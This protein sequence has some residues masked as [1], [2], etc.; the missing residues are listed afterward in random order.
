[1]KFKVYSCVTVSDITDNSIASVDVMYYL[2]TSNTEC[3]G[4]TW[5]TTPPPWE[6][7]KYYWQK[8]VTTFTDTSIQPSETQP[9]CI[10]GGKGQDGRGVQS[11]TEE[12]YLSTSKEE[13]IGGEWK[14]LNHNGLKA[15]IYGPEVKLYILT[16]LAQNTPK[17]IVIVPGKLLI[18]LKSAERTCF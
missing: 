3:I 10:T 12:Y 2:S 16:L 18:R 8:T 4:G 15:N 6:N 9:V 7:G 14:L 17:H 11:I 1:M 5:S 13:P